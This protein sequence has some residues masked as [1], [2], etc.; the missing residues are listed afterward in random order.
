MSPTPIADIAKQLESLPADDL[1]LLIKPYISMLAKAI[2]EETEIT[3]WMGSS[4]TYD[5]FV[6]CGG[7][8]DQFGKIKYPEDPPPGNPLGNLINRL[9]SSRKKSAQTST[10][11][12][13]VRLSAPRRLR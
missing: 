10:T 7:T 6:H 2:R 3:N 9:R 11:V 8:Q 12:L 1:E 4:S 13:E 5:S